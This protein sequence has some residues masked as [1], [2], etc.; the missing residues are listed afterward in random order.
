MLA[1]NGTYLEFNATMVSPPAAY[2]IRNKW[3]L[4]NAQFNFMKEIGHKHGIEVESV[5]RQTL[6]E[7]ILHANVS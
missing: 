6:R 3:A 1:R 4:P 7:C 5:R 2:R